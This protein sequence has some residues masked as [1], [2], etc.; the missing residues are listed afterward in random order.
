MTAQTLD[1]SSTP[2]LDTNRSGKLTDEQRRNL[3]GVERSYRKDRL[4]FALIAA[5]I[6]V[7][8]L[9]A[10]GPAPNAAYR[11]IV[12]L[13]LIAVAV[14]LLFY[15]LVFTDSLTRDLWSGRVEAVEGAVGKNSRSYSSGNSSSTSYYLDVGGKN[16]E[17]GYHTYEAVPDAGWIRLFYL[18]RSHKVVNWERLP[19]KA[20]P[21]SLIANPVQA[22]AQAFSALR[23]HDTTQLNEMRAE[24]ASLSSTMQSQWEAATS[25]PPP[26]GP[27]DPRPLTQS[28]LGKWQMGP[29]TVTFAA[30]GTVVET[31][32]GGRQQHG[33]W[34][35]SADGKLHSDVMGHDQAA[36]AWVT[37]DTLT[38]SSGD[39]RPISF[40]RS[41]A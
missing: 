9:T 11:P 14:V 25:A 6:G 26:D 41:A 28:I 23:S 1:P 15:G 24:M 10:S 19:D 8:V 2:E 32:F 35:V 12:G 39:D 37:G 33:H 13:G 34:S 3:K 27:R 40:K 22:V 18:P 36:Q 31:T 7:L 17:I 38:I 21:E 20:A 4:T 5:V 29:I 30:D 16:F